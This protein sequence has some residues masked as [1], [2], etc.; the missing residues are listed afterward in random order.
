[1]KYKEVILFLYEHSNINPSVMWSNKTEEAYL[2]H[3]CSGEFISSFPNWEKP[4]LKTFKHKKNCKYTK[5]LNI[6]KKEL[7]LKNYEV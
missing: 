1:M 7:N 4:T 2:C 3:G 5:V 6:L